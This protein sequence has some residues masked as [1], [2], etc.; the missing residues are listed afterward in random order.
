MEAA[1][2]EVGLAWGGGGGGGGGRQE[3]EREMREA[4]G[5]GHKREVRKERGREM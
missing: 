1:V 5:K 2:E 4:R 3:G